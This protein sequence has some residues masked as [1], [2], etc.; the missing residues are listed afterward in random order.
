MQDPQSFERQLSE[1]APAAIETDALTAMYRCGFAAGQASRFDSR[2]RPRPPWLK[3]AMAACLTAVL[4]GPLSYRLGHVQQPTSVVERREEPAA[5]V[6]EDPAG[7]KPTVE[8]PA[9]QAADSAN[10][11]SRVAAIYEPA[12]VSQPW[13]P[14]WGGWLLGITPPADSQPIAAPSYDIV[15]TS[16]PPSADTMAWLERSRPQQ[17]FSPAQVNA[18]LD[19]P[20]TSPPET[21]QNSNRYRLPPLPSRNSLHSWE[22]WIQS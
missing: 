10:A 20:D 9:S 15:L 18:V 7:V 19:V 21:G 4:V 12:N 2:V 11:A 16:R 13:S 3:L 14:L 6:V 8:T 22:P 17:P 5:R 1:L